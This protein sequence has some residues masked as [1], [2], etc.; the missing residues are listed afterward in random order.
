MTVRTEAAFRPRATVAAIAQRAESF[1]FVE[2]RV[3]GRNLVINQ[4]AGHLEAG[5]TLFAAVRREVL[6]ETRYDFQPEGLVGVY[7]CH[8][9]VG[10]CGYLRFCFH[11]RV[12]QQD[13]F[14]SLDSGIVRAVWLTREAMR[15][16]RH[17]SPLVSRCMDDYLAG[18]SWPLDVLQHMLVEDSP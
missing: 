4:P 3:S 17:R 14:R 8:G 12:G 10:Q 7:L 13:M 2:E 5:E 18:Q 16:H 9:E 11:G 6:E 15:Q 1:L